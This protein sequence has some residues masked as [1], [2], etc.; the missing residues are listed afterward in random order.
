VDEL[1]E[2]ADDDQ[3]PREGVPAPGPGAEG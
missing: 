2:A 3:A 1:G